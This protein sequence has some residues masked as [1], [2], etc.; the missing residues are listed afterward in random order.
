MPAKGPA[1][2]I[3]Q[4]RLSQRPQRLQPPRLLAIVS[5]RKTEAS[6][7]SKARRWL[8]FQALRS[9]QSELCRS[10]VITYQA[11]VTSRT[12]S[13]LDATSNISDHMGTGHGQIITEN[14]AIEA[15]L[16]PENVLKPAPRKTGGLTIDLGIDH[17][18]RHHCRQ[19][20]CQ[21]GKWHQVRLAQFIQAAIIYGN[22]H[23][24]I[25]LSP[26]M[27]RKMLAA[28]CHAR[29]S[30]A[31]DERPTQL[32]NTLRI[33]IE[34]TRTN[35]RTAPMIQ[36]EHWS[37]TQIQPDRQHLGCHQPAT[38]PGQ[39]LGIIALGDLPHGW[40]PDEPFTQA[41]HPPTF[42]IDRND[43]V[44]AQSTYGSAQLPHL[45]RVG[46]ITSKDDQTSYFRLEQ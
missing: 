2:S 40:Q 11:H 16:P 32:S 34:G 25:G 27:P 3:D 39:T 45:T 4:L 19:L 26:A 36:I 21:S 1:R 14:H 37:K 13:S 23:M 7:P 35:D 28:C 20:A 42:L 30:H 9:Q 22:G 18:C 6:H 15:K 38:M 24:R 44:R 46:N 17:M 10:P 43:Q 41:L 29:C 33:T 12:E 5:A 8:D 31:T